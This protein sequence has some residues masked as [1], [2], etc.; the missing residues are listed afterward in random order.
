MTKILLNIESKS[1]LN[2]LCERLQ[3]ENYTTLSLS[4]L[5]QAQRVAEMESASVAI[6]DENSDI[7]TLPLPTIIIAKSPNIDS[8]IE[9][10][11][12]LAVALV[13]FTTWKPVNTIW[14]AYLFGVLYWMNYYLP[15]LTR[16]SQELFKMLPYLI[17]IVVL[18]I[19]SLRKKKE[20]Q[21]P[22]NLGLA[23]FREER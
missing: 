11:G 15:G 1:L 4:D 7:T 18:I 17:T 14:G 3:F 10:L 16:Y 8:A 9:A 12:W 19:T 5:S 13:I 22:A 6:V 20:N 2:S 23:Y 21:P